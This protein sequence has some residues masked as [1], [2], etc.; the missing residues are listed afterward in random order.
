MT[1]RFAPCMSAWY[2]YLKFL[3]YHTTRLLL[4]VMHRK[5]DKNLLLTR[6]STVLVSIIPAQTSK[7]YDFTPIV[8]RPW[9]VN[10]WRLASM[11]ANCKSTHL[12]CRQLSAG[13]QFTS[14]NE[15]VH[16]WAR[17]SCGRP[18]SCW[19][20]PALTTFR[21]V[22][23]AAPPRRTSHT[24]QWLSCASALASQVKCGWYF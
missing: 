13:L 15:W 5:G 3:T 2:F 8:K 19:N 12:P 17:S 9:A 18:G 1:Q 7:V 14:C 6:R 11:H 22:A 16:S 20:I 4:V 23:Y 24:Q 21:D 10:R